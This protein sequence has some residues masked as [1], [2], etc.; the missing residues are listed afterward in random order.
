MPAVISDFLR[1]AQFNVYTRFY[2]ALFF[3]ELMNFKADLQLMKC[4]S[5]HFIATLT[6]PCSRARSSKIERK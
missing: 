3:I 1:N 5:L 6:P 4:V 2:G